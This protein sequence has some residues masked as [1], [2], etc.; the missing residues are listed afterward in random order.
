MDNDFLLTQ[1]AMAAAGFLVA[2]LYVI[3]RRLKQKK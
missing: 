3:Y 2:A 1:F